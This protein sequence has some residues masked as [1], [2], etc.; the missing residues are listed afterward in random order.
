MALTVDGL[1][2]IALFAAVPVKP[3]AGYFGRVSM[4]ENVPEGS[5][6]FTS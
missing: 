2:R 3:V 1:I 4:P 6:L 5:F